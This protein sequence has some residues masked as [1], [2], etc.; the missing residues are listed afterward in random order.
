MVGEG[1]KVN[2]P[3]ILTMTRFLFIPLFIVVFFN[4]Y[5]LSAYGILLIA[6][7]TDV[8]D[9]YLARK[10]NQVTYLGSMLDPLADKLMMLTVIVSLL[11]A[12]YISFLLA[13][14]IFFRDAGMI[15]SS[16]VFHFRGKKTVPANTLGKITTVLFYLAVLLIIFELP[17]HKEFLWFVVSFAFLTSFNYVREFQKL[18][19]R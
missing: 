14:L 8:L 5:E 19:V 17:Y 7:I 6:G 3:N 2:L 16:L 15:V 10:N 11:I 1:T 18:N 13:E 4:G 9:G 12:E